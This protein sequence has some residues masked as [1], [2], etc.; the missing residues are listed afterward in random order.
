MLLLR[1][2]HPV[3]SWC[4]LLLALLGVGLVIYVAGW[5]DQG[6][7]GEGAF[8]AARVVAFCYGG[9]ALL[10]VVSAPRPGEFLLQHWL[11]SFLAL[12]V[13]LSSL[14]EA[15]LSVWLEH[16]AGTLSIHN[17]LLVIVGLQQ[18]LALGARVGEAVPWLE[19]HLFE[20]FSLGALLVG[21]FV[22]FALIGALLLMMPNATVDGIGFLDALFTSTSAVC[23]TGLIV[24]DTATAFTSLGQLVILGLIQVGGL[25]IV[26]LTF[27]VA[28]VA[29]QGVTVSSR[30]FLRDMLNSDNLSRLG[31]ALGFILLVTFSCE[32][33]GAVMI[34]QSW[35]G[36]DLEGN[37]GWLAAFHS[38][39]AFCNAG[40]SL[41]SNGLAEPE[42]VGNRGG[43]LVIMV[44]VI[45]GGIG[46]PVLRE[47][48]L[49]LSQR[50]RKLFPRLIMERAGLSLHSRLAL[51]ST[52]VLL[53]GGFALLLLA[54]HFAREASW[55]EAVWTSLFRTVSARTAGFNIGDIGQI[56]N[57]GAAVMMFL[58]FVGGSPGGLAGGIKTTTLAVAFLNLLRILRRRRDVTL[59]RRR[60]HESILQRA[61]AVV[62]LSVFWILCASGAI[63]LVQPELDF[64]DTLFEAVSAFA[65]VG[66]TRGIT[67]ELGSFSK[68]VIILTMLVGR[69][70]ILNFFL[71]LLPIKEEPRMRLPTGN[72]IV[73]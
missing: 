24:V 59:F 66:V 14:F 3:A 11:T 49:L 46:F 45:V 27:F 70:G 38:I 57:M 5:P 12:A 56:S 71:S 21:T 8:Q 6:I 19:R 25:G 32:F 48:G 62:L 9:A 1:K 36:L 2:F 39:S 29:G 28:L 58:M 55:D 54:S 50:L 26:T 34:Y 61:F 15:E 60:I 35:Q 72:V 65:T 41:F 64:L 17:W 44:L 51:L 13:V 10:E 42:V 47:L 73:D 16:L 68:C 40:F 7:W 18:L 53:V 22:L 33:L 20:R 63:M 4:Q 69:V 23:V 30:V 67:P 52:L 37:L 43:Q 31:S